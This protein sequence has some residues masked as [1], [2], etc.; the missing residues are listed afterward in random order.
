MPLPLGLAYANL[1][2][3]EIHVG[4]VQSHH[5]PSPTGRELFYRQG[6]EFWAV[7]VETETEFRAGTPRLLFEAPY[8]NDSVG[9]GI[10]NYDV[11]LDGQQFLMMQSDATNEATGYAVV[12]NWF[13]ELKARVPTN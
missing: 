3:P 7:E 6:P 13:E 10:P 5:L 2:L 9:V 4:P 11:S 12:L 1:L 8:V